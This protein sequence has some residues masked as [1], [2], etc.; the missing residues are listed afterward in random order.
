MAG[1][2]ALADGN[3]AAIRSMSVSAS[4]KIAATP[5]NLTK[6]KT[7]TYCLTFRYEAIYE[8]CMKTKASDL[9]NRMINV[10]QLN[11]KVW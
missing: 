3:M 11:I 1:A 6:A 5:R 9:L 7:F 8:C 10:T 2:V 4:C